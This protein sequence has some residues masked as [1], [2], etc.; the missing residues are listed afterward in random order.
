MA[1]KTKTTFNFQPLVVVSSEWEDWFIETRKISLCKIY[2]E[3]Y[4]F[5]RTGCKGCPFAIDI[6]KELD[7]LEKFLP[8]E[9]KQC[10]LIWGPVYKEYRRL[11]YRLRQNEEEIQI[12]GQMNIFD[13]IS[14]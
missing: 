10:E 6:Q 14:E 11:G 3:P 7:A 8:N 5:V 9:L 1:W 13:F 4:N 2:G 12:P